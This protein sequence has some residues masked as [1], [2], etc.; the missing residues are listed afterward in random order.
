LHAK[1]RPSIKALVE[2]MAADDR[3]SLA[4][5]LELLVEAEADRRK[6]AR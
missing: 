4:R 1:V 5:W 6:A 3:R 2:T